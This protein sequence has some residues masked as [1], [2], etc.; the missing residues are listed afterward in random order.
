[1]LIKVLVTHQRTDTLFRRDLSHKHLS[2]FGFVFTFGT[3]IAMVRFPRRNFA[4][5]PTDHSHDAIGT[6]LSTSPPSS[7][8]HGVQIPRE[9]LADS[10]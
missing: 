9:M 10:T 8:T 5:F 3:F 2:G 4:T 6:A 7:D 1:M